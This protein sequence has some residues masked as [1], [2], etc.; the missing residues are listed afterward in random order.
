MALVDPSTCQRQLVM[1]TLPNEVRTPYEVVRSVRLARPAGVLR[2]T[3]DAESLL[4][5][6]DSC[7]YSMHRVIA[8]C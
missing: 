2:M 4:Q 3:T 6:S 1:F 7:T 8:V 5:K